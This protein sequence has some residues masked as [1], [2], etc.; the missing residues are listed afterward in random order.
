MYE[1]YRKKQVA[2]FFCYRNCGMFVYVDDDGVIRHIEGD[3]DHP[4]NFGGMCPRPHTWHQFIDHPQRVNY[5]MKRDGKRGDGRWKRITWEQAI[6][7]ISEKLS[8][9]REECGAEAVATTGGT[10]R[11]DDLARRRFFNLFG[12]PNSFHPEHDCWCNNFCIE[13]GIYGWGAAGDLGNARCLVLWGRNSGGTAIPEFRSVLDARDDHG[14]KIIAV[15]PRFNE[16][17]SKADILL[18]L[19]PGTDCAMALA[20]LNVII[21]E[22]LYDRK[23]VESDCV[24]FEKLAEHVKQYTPEWA[25]EVTWVPKEKIIEAAR[26]YATEKPGCIVWGVGADHIGRNAGEAVHAR[27][28]LRVV[29][30]NLNVPGADALSGPHPTLQ[31]TEF[32]LN[33]K[34]PQEQ[35]DKQLGSDRYKL[36]TWPGYAR[37][38][39]LAKKHW[40]KYAPA[41]WFCEAHP[42]AVWRAIIDEDPYPVRALITL[43]SNPLLSYADTNHVYRALTS[44]NLEL[45]VVMDYWVTPSAALADYVLPAASWL[46]RPTLQDALGVTNWYLASERAIE[47]MHERH[48]DYEFW[49]DLGRALGQEEYWPWETNEEM[50]FHR[51]NND[52][53]NSYVEFVKFQRMDVH[54]HEVEGYATP[55]GKVELYSTV[56]DEF[57]YPPMP[58]Y[59]EPCES[60]VSTPELFK[61]YP[62]VLTTGAKAMPYHH[63]EGHHIPWLRRLRPDPEMEVHPDAAAAY[64]LTEG[65]WAFIETPRGKIQQKVKL[66]PANDPRV[67]FAQHGWW[68]PEKEEKEPGLFGLW[69]SNVNVLTPDDDRCCDPMCGSWYYRGMLCKVYPR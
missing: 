13:I 41:E 31:T 16:T 69:E 8:S 29:T 52:T 2:C 7:E 38:E 49:R 46:E 50:N 20:W 30:G 25:E 58:V 36:I 35:R 32:E 26:T 5:P 9:I 60:P 6:K 34:L 27:A 15:D 53:F 22:G 24:G 33:E 37:F 67:V 21:G 68:D 10:N 43:A 18:Q 39:E 45:H 12:S 55:S 59:E 14:A 66:N 3:D 42:T 28:L 63:S 51:I 54:M 47:P 23:F 4:V 57:G 17:S 1:D 62:L 61:E 65:E 19:R 11:T 48:T 44:E 64:G 56:L 40:G